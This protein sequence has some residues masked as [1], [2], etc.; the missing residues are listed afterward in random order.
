[1]SGIYNTDPRD[2]S[3][4]A[5][6]PR[7]RKLEQAHGSLT[8]AMLE[9]RKTPSRDANGAKPSSMFVSFKD[10]M[11]TLVNALVKKLNGDLCLHTGVKQIEQALPP[12]LYVT[13]S[14]CCGV[15]VPDCVHQAQ[16]TV[17]RARQPL[18]GVLN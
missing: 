10:G 9:A 17:A 16:E 11:Q 1:M 18:H 7:F 6:F 2:Q 13:G 14:V 8:R 12:R 4:L 15:G 3:L 5:I